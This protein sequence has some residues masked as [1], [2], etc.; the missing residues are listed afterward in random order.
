MHQRRY[1]GTDGIRGL[2]NSG[3]LHPDIVLR[4]GHAIG[5]KV[6]ESH[7]GPERPRVLLVRDT[8]VSGPMISGILAGGLL[9]HGVDVLD[10]GVLPT[11]ACALVVRRESLALGLV[12]SASHN[13]MPDNGIKLFGPDGRKLSDDAEV[14]IERYIDQAASRDTGLTGADVG[15]LVPYARAAELYL[16]AMGNEFFRDL[17]LAGRR[18]V[19]DCSHGAGS[20]ITPRVLA[21]LGAEVLAINAEPDGLNINRDVGVF[22]ADRLAEVVRREKADFG[23]SLDGD[24]DRVVMVDETGGVLDGDDILAIL[25]GEIDAGGPGLVATVMSNLGLKV[26]LKDRGIAFHETPVGDRYVAERMASTGARIGGEQ[27]GHVILR[28]GDYWFGDGAYTALRIAEIMARTGKPLSALA[29]AMDRF[30]QVLQN[31]P[32]SEKP[33]LSE[34]SR[35]QETQRRHQIALGDEGRILVRYSGTES[36]ARVMVEGRDRDRIAEVARDLVEA[37][38]AEIG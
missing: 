4:I 14:D 26:L 11:P 35:L 15:R 1:F 8:R 22:H 29:T 38:R 20:V 24:G 12:V 19:I 6:R 21:A 7:P 17:D 5:R 28:E 31:V 10:G 27:S 32:V 2:A 18:V 37:I 25:A 9:G 23:F 34:L 36:L 33:P 13:P 3:N 16:E 30:P